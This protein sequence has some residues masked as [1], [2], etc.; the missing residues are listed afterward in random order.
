[1]PKP[2]FQ[3]FEIPEFERR[4]A[5][6]PHRNHFGSSNLKR[7]QG[8]AGREF[9]NQR[10]LGSLNRSESEYGVRHL[11]DLRVIDRN[12]PLPY[13]AKD[14]RSRAWGLFALGILLVIALSAVIWWLTK[15]RTV[16]GV[17]PSYEIGDAQPSVIEP[18]SYER[19]W[20]THKTKKGETF[21]AIADRFGIPKEEEDKIATSMKALPSE[22][23]FQGPLKAG[24]LLNFQFSKTGELSQLM[25]QPEANREMVLRR[26]KNGTFVAKVQSLQGVIREHVAVGTIRSSFAGAAQEAGVSYDVVDELVDLFSNRIEFNKDFQPGDRFSVIYRMPVLRDGSPIGDPQILAAAL[27]VKG[28]HLV[29]A[30]YVGSDGKARFFDEKGN[31][32]GNSFLRYPLKFSRISSYFSEARFHPV[33]KFT[34]PHNGIDFAAPIG[35]PVR[36]VADGVVVFAGYKGGN[37]NMVRIRHNNRYSTAYLHL[38]AIGKG[39]HTG[40]HIQRGQV[41]GA[42]GMTG[43]ATGPHLHFSFYDG[44]KYV[45]PLKTL[46]PMLDS[47]EDGKNIDGNYLKKVLFTLDHYQNVTLSKFYSGED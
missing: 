27:E 33:L 10:N 29:A 6:E 32:L 34:R 1:M 36:T 21:H 5:E 9:G 38:S 3:N 11:P 14:I 19:A 40:A 39:V 24:R 31:L 25:W 46:L 26:A 16:V 47:L 13:E 7:G 8:R 43:L 18:P 42:V 12:E 2:D 45:N 41:I 44:D 4:V 37:G 22:Y 23:S 17:L 15:P 35:T 30:R 28:E 20:V